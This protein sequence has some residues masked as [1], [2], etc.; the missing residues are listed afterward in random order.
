LT[1]DLQALTSHHSSLA[2][3]LISRWPL[4]R[5]MTVGRVVDNASAIH[6][7]DTAELSTSGDEG[8]VCRLNAGERAGCLFSGAS[9]SLFG[10]LSSACFRARGGIWV[11]PA[12]FGN[13]K[14]RFVFSK[15]RFTENE[16]ALR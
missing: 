2:E 15:G 13:P 14:G 3:S 9:R 12:L 6:G 10:Y 4:H 5:G 8:A 7:G 1:K 11:S 16:G